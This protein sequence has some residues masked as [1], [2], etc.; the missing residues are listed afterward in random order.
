M[1]FF[2]LLSALFALFTYGSVLA[3]SDRFSDA[4]RSITSK[5]FKLQESWAQY[6]PYFP[7]E[8]YSDPPKRCRVIQANIIQRHGARYPTSGASA[9]IVTALSKLMSATNYTDP[10]LQFLKSY[11][12]SLGTDDLVPFGA[13]ESQQAG[14]LH[15]SRYSS[16]VN[17]RQLPFVRASGSERVILS[18]TNWTAGFSI[19][20]SHVY[21]PK[22]SVI[23]S[24][25]LNDTLDD[26]MC[27]NAGSS[28][29]QTSEWLLTYGPPIAD[30]LNKQAPGANVT[31]TDVY[32][33]LSLCPF[34][35][36]SF[37]TPSPFCNLF[38]NAEFRQFEYS[39]DLDKYYNTGY[40]QPLGPVQGVG[41]INELLARLTGKPVRDNTQ[42][43]RTLDASP[44]T[45]PLNR[46]I[47]ADFS[48]DNQMI[49]IYTA[50]GLFRQAAAPDPTLPN[51]RRNW[52]A[53][54]LVP[55]SARMVTEKVLCGRKEYVRVFVND[56]LQ[57]LE[58]CG[59]GK[60]GLCELGAFVKSQA[61]ARNN[62]NGDFNKCFD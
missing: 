39:G 4:S 16:L 40:G 21:N 38:S 19:A 48:H 36:V 17:H 28:S 61:Y 14:K 15:F 41:Y 58:F 51:P 18:A 43:N 54:H 9:M 26:S 29:S 25:D 42:T 44:I 33:L 24:E 34:E 32:S 2:L 59:A 57:P 35:S 53:S 45:F 5:P 27:P 62:G 3:I 10:S 20:S 52:L 30:R 23:L 47:Y 1:A 7:V 50:M 8:E 6:S 12:Y 31:S 49:A 55:F 37:D 60:D 46:T 13:R 11:T 56:A 22:L